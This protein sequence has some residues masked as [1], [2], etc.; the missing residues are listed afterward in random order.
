ML[1][2][3]SLCV[4]LLLVQQVVAAPAP[5]RVASPLTRFGRAPFG[6]AHEVHGLCFTP[7]GKQLVTTGY[8]HRA[9]LWD[10]AT[11]HEVRVFGKPEIF[12]QPFSY[13]RWVYCAAVSPDGRMLA[14]GMYA[15]GWQ[16]GSI[17]LWDMEKG[18]VIRHIEVGR[19]GVTSLVF[20]PDGAAVYAGSSNGEASLWEVATGRELE[21]SQLVAGLVQTVG[22]VSGGKFGITFANGSIQYCDLAANKAITPAE[23]AP[24]SAE[25]IACSMDG[26]LLAVAD[27]SKAIHLW[28]LTTWKE[29][30]LLEGHQKPIRGLGFSGDGKH[31]AS[32]DEGGSMRIWDTSTGKSNGWEGGPPSA[33]PRVVGVGTGGKFAASAVWWEG[34]ARVWESATGKLAYPPSGHAGSVVVTS[35]S[36]NGTLSTAAT[37]ETLRQWRPDEP[38]V[39]SAKTGRYA[40]AFS[41]DG[42][43]AAW[44]DAKGQIHLLDW[45][46]GKEILQFPAHSTAISGLS[47]LPG[48]KHLI[49][50]GGEKLLRIWDLSGKEVGKLEA[51]GPATHLRFN[52]DGSLLTC[53]LSNGGLQAGQVK[54]GALQHPTLPDSVTALSS[55]ALSP[56]GRWL[57][58]GS[59]TNSVYV[60]GTDRNAPPRELS[61]PRGY[62]MSVAFSPDGRLL[63]AGGWGSIHL[64]EVATWG[65][66]ARLEGVNGDTISLCF[67]P[68]ARSV[69]AGG[70]NGWVGSFDLAGAARNGKPKVRE[71]SATDRDDLWKTLMSHQVDNAYR[72][73]WTLA[74]VPDVVF[75]LL[76]E[77]LKPA[78]KADETDESAT[79]GRQLFLLEQLR[80]PQARKLLE[81]LA[82][83]EA[84]ATLT[85]SAKT[86]LDR[87]GPK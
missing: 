12:V 41:S 45:K 34:R 67:A 5:G 74:D 73:L 9:R 30:R 62:V 77:T 6:H 2:C 24:K 52:A 15:K 47:F 42:L 39:V 38:L 56:D 68:N 25:A 46:T 48:N 80:T 4:G 53:L 86:A 26:K 10:I 1:R 44:G 17:S 83:G 66:I 49:S 27:T 18:T 33:E 71:V 37:D 70:L 40:V 61:G 82:A 16:L 51:S 13:E 58:A 60:W 87:L 19:A 50:S 84:K 59:Q 81:E 32:I 8:D 28:D 11:G 31:M 64:F 65:E 21:R 63:A 75:P 14:T 23:G 79:L 69:A 43:S 72:A 54:G 36:P 57:V 76:K 35:I 3:I 20:S 78:M 29:L 7:D 85:R 55:C 22:L